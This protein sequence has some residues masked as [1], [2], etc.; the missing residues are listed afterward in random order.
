MAAPAQNRTKLRH[1]AIL[2]APALAL[3]CAFALLK[4]VACL[5]DAHSPPAPAGTSVDPMPSSVPEEGWRHANDRIPIDSRE[6][7]RPLRLDAQR[8][9]NLKLVIRWAASIGVRRL[10][11]LVYAVRGVVGPDASLTLLEERSLG[12]L[13]FQKD[14][15]VEHDVEEVLL[16]LP[17][18]SDVLCVLQ[19]PTPLRL[20]DSVIV[21]PM[22]LPLLRVGAD[23]QHER[24][25]DLRVASRLALSPGE[26]VSECGA[27][28]VSI[29]LDLK[30]RL[31]KTFAITPMRPF[32]LVGVAGTPV[33]AWASGGLLAFPIR[34]VP[35]RISRLALPVSASSCTLDLESPI[36]RLRLYA[37]GVP[38]ADSYRIG[39]GV[40]ELQACDYRTE[41]G[42]LSLQSL[43]DA[44]WSRFYVQPR[45]RAI[46]CIS[47]A[48]VRHGAD[49]DVRV[50]VSPSEPAVLEV[51]ADRSLDWAA[52]D[53]FARP[54]TGKHD[55][56]TVR[57]KDGVWLVGPLT[58][59]TWD[60]YWKRSG[61]SSYFPA[62]LGHVVK[63][64]A[65]SQL[66]CPFREPR[67]TQIRFR[68]W[69]TTP[70]EHRPVSVRIDGASCRRL[71][72]AD[73]V[74]TADLMPDDLHAPR[75]LLVVP[76]IGGTV[77]AEDVRWVGSELEATLPECSYG[78][79]QVL[80][81]FG[82]QVEARVFTVP[83]GP[84]SLRVPIG[85][86]IQPSADGVFRIVGSTGIP[87]AAFELD[88]RTQDRVFLGFFVGDPMK[89]RQRVDLTGRWIDVIA[90]DSGVLMARATLGDSDVEAM[91]NQ[92]LPAG[93]SRVWLPSSAAV[94]VFTSATRKRA[95]A[96]SGVAD[97]VYL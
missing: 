43:L 73:G 15:N 68:N 36:G 80:P 61:S 33:S 57:S 51:T 74:Y 5:L 82:G 24:E 46:N 94:V 71:T 96:T 49:G 47:I 22:P 48:E 50:D 30:E 7:S 19:S 65:K 32:V 53:V 55:G 34:L 11:L 95:V 20:E 14:L 21:A 76:S 12:A 27:I 59:G 91:M 18:R 54:S 23:E 78:E 60:L 52:W 41:H 10:E 77:T 37:D 90:E 4:G 17:L 29:E 67:R 86:V 88:A 84:N 89:K 31:L 81:R 66:V 85:R 3:L 39:L 13:L 97:L 62:C 83:E 40:P 16:A 63:P 42:L 72:N 93:R 64:G 38:V 69:N 26:R 44:G 58:P 56:F 87:C 70:I 1:R 79:L 25:L 9:G 6:E 35:D 75:I 2:L 45:G 92:R 28:T 8:P